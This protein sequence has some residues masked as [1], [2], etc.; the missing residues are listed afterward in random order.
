MEDLVQAPLQGHPESQPCLEQRL[1]SWRFA[2]NLNT[3]SHEE[4][5]SRLGVN[6]QAPGDGG[7]GLSRVSGSHHSH[8]QSPSAGRGSQ[9]R[10][11]L[12]KSLLP[13]DGPRARTQVFRP[14]SKSL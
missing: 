1:P 2:P 9:R 11:C 10:K 7:E 6:L 13:P 12:V 3:M 4:E 14:G 8:S 5:G